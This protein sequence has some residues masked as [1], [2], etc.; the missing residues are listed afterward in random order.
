MKSSHFPIPIIIIAPLIITALCMVQHAHAMNCELAGQLSA[1]VNEAEA[2]DNWENNSGIRYIPQLTLSRQFS[3]D[4]LFD[5]ELSLNGYLSYDTRDT[6]D[7]SDVELYRFKIRLATPKLEA[8]LGLQKISF[9]PALLLRSLQWF[10]RLDP[11]DPQKL[12]DGVYGFRLKYSTLN[13]ANYWFWILK[14]NDDLKGLE[15]LPSDSGPPEVGGRIQ[16]PVP[17]GEVAATFHTRKVNL[18]PYALPDATENR[19]A[20]DGRWDK[21]IG[22]WF[23]TVLQEQRIDIFPFT[24]VKFT[25]VGMDYTV[26]VGNGLYV[27]A[28]HLVTSLSQNKWEWRNCYNFSAIHLRYPI[29]FFDAV[30]VICYYNWDEEKPASY[31]SWSRTLDKFDITISL[32]K[33]P[34]TARSLL[35]INRDDTVRGSGGEVL[36][37]YH[38]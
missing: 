21:I 28:E 10:D 19:Y 32:F 24:W 6:S 13:N 12:T 30:S 33:Y 27:L 36:F 38:H 18:T 15:F 20:L 35:G 17:H 29:G 14:D 25:T 23:E 31:A 5:V 2:D 3:E 8:R 7:N 34:E 16:Y 9:G 37:I 4:L 26:G 22:F 1:W 11:R